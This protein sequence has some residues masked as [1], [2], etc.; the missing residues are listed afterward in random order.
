MFWRVSETNRFSQY[1]LSRSFLYAHFSLTNFL[2]GI[3]AMPQFFPVTFL[4]CEFIQCS[5]LPPTFIQRNISS[6]LHC[7]FN[8][9]LYERQ[10]ATSF[11]NCFF[12]SLIAICRIVNLTEYAICWESADSNETEW[13]PK[14]KGCTWLVSHY[15]YTTL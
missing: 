13:K 4:Q 10:S 12:S 14:L 15:T 2:R 5:L 7:S 9:E 3:S 1:D 6:M 8:V 11:S